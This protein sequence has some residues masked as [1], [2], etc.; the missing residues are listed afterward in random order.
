MFVDDAPLKMKKNARASR[1]FCRGR[2]HPATPAVRKVSG[3]RQQPKTIADNAKALGY[4]FTRVAGSR[5]THKATARKLA[6]FRAN[7]TKARAQ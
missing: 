5:D 6:R 7:L 3:V 4:L 2:R 1:P